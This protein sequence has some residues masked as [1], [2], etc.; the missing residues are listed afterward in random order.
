MFN[1][2][3]FHIAFVITMSLIFTF[4]M[5][6]ILTYVFVGATPH[7]FSEWMQDWG[8]AFIIA[9]ILNSF[10]P[11]IIQK[12]IAG[13]SN[14]VLRY[15]IGAALVNTIVL[16][17]ALVSYALR[18]WSNPAFLNFWLLHAWPV[19]M[20]SATILNLFLPKVVGKFIGNYLIK[21]ELA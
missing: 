15:A 17:F 9:I 10:V 16:S 1:K 21:A 8:I 12:R 6:A 20:V 7:Y 4:I 14:P 13:K 3:Y 18:G 11:G 5:S 2:K 19:A